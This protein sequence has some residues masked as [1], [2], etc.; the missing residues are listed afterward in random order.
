MIKLKFLS[1]LVLMG[2]PIPAFAVTVED[3]CNANVRGCSGIMLAGAYPCGGRVT[4]C[5][6]KT[7]PGMRY[8]CGSGRPT[9]LPRLLLPISRAQLPPIQLKESGDGLKVDPPTDLAPQ[10]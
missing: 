6:S 1:L 9:L 7:P 5:K 2:A 8:S 4:I 10:R 3:C